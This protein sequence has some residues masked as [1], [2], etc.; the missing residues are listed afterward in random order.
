MP[1]G[2]HKKTPDFNLGFGKTIKPDQAPAGGSTGI[3]GGRVN[4]LSEARLTT[5]SVMR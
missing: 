5:I 3:T 2:N 1:T 4:E